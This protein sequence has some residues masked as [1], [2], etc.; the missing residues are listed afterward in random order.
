MK[1]NEIEKAASNT[2]MEIPDYLKEEMDDTR[3]NEGVTKEDLVIP[4]ISIVQALSP[5]LKS[6]EPEYIE[7][8][9]QGM[10]FN[11][12]TRELYTSLQ[13]VPVTFMKSWLL[14]KDRKKGGGFGG[15]FDD[16]Q[17]AIDEMENQENPNDWEV[18]DTPTHFCLAVT[19]SGKV[20]EVVI[21]MP[22]SK[23]KI[24]RQFNSLIRIN[25]GPRFS[26]AYEISGVG[27][28]NGAGEDFWNFAVKNHGFI[29]EE[30]FRIAERA[31]KD[32]YEGSK[33][34]KVDDNYSDNTTPDSTAF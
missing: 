31:Y 5:E 18:T 15:S 11:T 7:G 34:F 30:L 1:K 29:P 10:L 16:E 32:I 14:W 20:E 22:K 25:G 12:L 33:I 4:R 27:D 13:I 24:S 3:G 17:S 19:P 28:K 9:E 6:K 8:A 26:R 21:P 23:A 2:L